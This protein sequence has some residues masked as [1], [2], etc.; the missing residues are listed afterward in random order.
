MDRYFAFLANDDFVAII[1]V[2]FMTGGAEQVVFLLWD[3]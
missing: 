3:S 1:D 2:S